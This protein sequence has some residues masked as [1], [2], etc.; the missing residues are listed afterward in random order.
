[1][2]PNPPRRVLASPF[3][4]LGVLAALAVVV[5]IALSGDDDPVDTSSLQTAPVTVDGIGLLPL[6][7]P[8]PA[9]GE[10]VPTLSGSTFDGSEI[11]LEPGIPR[12]YGFFAHWCPHCQAELPKLTE[13]LRDGVGA[14]GVEV[15]AI[16]TAVEPDA[17]NHPPSAWFD[18]V[19]YEW[20]VLLD[21]ETSTAAI[22]FGLV[23]FPYWVVTDADGTVLLRLTGS[24]ERDDFVALTQLAADG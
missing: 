18:D 16:S 24:L 23:A 11:V 21:S 7:S 15:A 14:A 10:V 19:G 8:D 3:L 1:M 5:S 13:W 17:D 20:P 4:W 2:T 9:L 22:A 12:L 6:A